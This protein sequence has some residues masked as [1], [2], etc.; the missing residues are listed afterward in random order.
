MFC[1]LFLKKICHSD[2][3]SFQEFNIAVQRESYPQLRS[4]LQVK[5]FSFKMKLFFLLVVVPFAIVA[6]DVIEDVFVDPPIFIGPPIKRPPPPGPTTT[7]APR[8][9]PKK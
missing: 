3:L 8:I 7:A 5:Q 4:D 2:K 6:Q 1:E 9:L